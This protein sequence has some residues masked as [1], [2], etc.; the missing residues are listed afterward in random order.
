MSLLTKLLAPTPFRIENVYG[1]GYRITDGE[2][3]EFKTPWSVK[4]VPA[5]LSHEFPQTWSMRAEKFWQANKDNIDE[6]LAKQKLERQA[7][8]TWSKIPGARTRGTAVR[9][10]PRRKA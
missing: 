4:G 7:T 6:V 3:V 10:N 1:F 2:L 9:P 5:S 8:P